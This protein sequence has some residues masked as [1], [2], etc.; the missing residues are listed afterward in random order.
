M[1]LTPLQNALLSLIANAASS[2][3]TDSVD[4]V[5][6][7]LGYL[8]F[9]LYHWIE[10]DGQDI[11][12]QSDLQWSSNDIDALESAGF[13]TK[14][15]EW[16]NPKDDLNT[17][18]TYKLKV[19]QI[20]P[21]SS[22]TLGRTTDM[23]R[24]AA[25]LVA[26]PFVLVLLLVGAMELREGKLGWLTAETF[27]LGPIPVVVLVGLVMFTVFLPLLWLAS[28]FIR[29]TFLNTAVIGLMAALLP[30]LLAAWP[31]L[32]DSKLRL[33]FRVEHLAEAY[34]WLVMGAVGGLIFCLLAVHR[35]PAL[36]R[37]A[38]KS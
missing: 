25:S 15:G 6:E 20:E 29:I 18:V 16:R 12:Q 2:R 23:L 26:V 27:E 30:V 9:G 17:K 34:P 10:C 3:R 19:R 5:T 28:R 32:S 8:P 33:N 31:V 24:L 13:L 4:Y 35:N 37:L 11:S 7:W 1:Q 38:K 36:N 21:V 22:Q 14:V